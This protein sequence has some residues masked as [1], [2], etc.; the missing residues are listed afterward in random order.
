MKL[1]YN[2][3]QITYDKNWVNLILDELQ[4]GMKYYLVF[5]N[6]LTEIFTHSNIKRYLLFLKN[7]V[8]FS[9]LIIPDNSLICESSWSLKYYKNYDIH[10]IAQCG[11]NFLI[12][13]KEKYFI[14]LN[15]IITK[16]CK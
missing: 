2:F 5:R 11:H 14:I 15:N 7:S 10:V 6:I 16:Y 9:S 8:S 12:D 4:L 3:D 13:S 1:I